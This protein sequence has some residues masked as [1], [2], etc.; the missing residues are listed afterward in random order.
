MER[1]MHILRQML[2]RG[3]I[4]IYIQTKKLHINIDI[5][6]RANV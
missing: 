1:I 6:T 3:N 2:M 5:N 4:N